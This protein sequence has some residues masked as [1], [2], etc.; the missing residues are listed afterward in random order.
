LDTYECVKTKLDIHDFSSK[1]VPADLKLKTLEAGRLT[2][3]ERNIQHWR[4]IL[5]QE[6]RSLERL[7]EDSTTGKWAK[8]A[9]FAIIVLTDPQH[10]FNMLDSGRAIQDMQLAAWNYGVASGIFTGIKAEELRKDFD[11]PRELNPTVVVGFGYPARKIFGKKSRKP[12]EDVAFL[13]KYGNNLKPKM[14]G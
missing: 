13:E 7:A 1:A 11:I 12:L 5:L 6:R 10:K 8:A 2:G 14:L 9:N 3:S 4:F